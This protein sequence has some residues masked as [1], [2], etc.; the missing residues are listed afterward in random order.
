MDLQRRNEPDNFERSGRR[1]TLTSLLCGGLAL[2]AVA[3]A[4][5]LFR[6]PS[7]Q[8]LFTGSSAPV[9]QMEPGV[10]A[11]RF[12]MELIA[13][14]Q[15]LQR[16]AALRRAR[17]QLAEAMGSLAPLAAP[18]GPIT[19]GPIAL[20]VPV[21]RSRPVAAGLMADYGATGEA[22]QASTA[23]SFD[24]SSA[25]KNVFAMLPP[26]LKLASAS[27]DG[28]I[29]GDG[30]DEAPDLS[31]YGKQTALYDIS[32]RTVYMPDGSRLEAHSGLG[33]YLDDV[34][35]INVRDKGPT[36]PNVYELSP[37]EKPF[38]GVQAL[39]M[40]PVGEGDLFGRSGLLTH[41]YLMGPTGDSNGCVSFKDYDAFL[42]AF[43][44]GEVKRLVVVKS[45][46]DDAVKLARRS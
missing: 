19:T 3:A 16:D 25:I 32:A 34:R 12:P 21:P 13:T 44:N 22:K 14:P 1:L 37:R 33:G 17:T 27:P 11:S 29:S 18:E 23:G 26:G 24:V 36:P 31:A 28:G 43:T 35:F 5:V 2:A 38:H 46:R 41:S 15:A 42:K 20:K 4:A 40:K 39:R 30:K 10:F 45:T 9:R 8:G 7:G 6:V